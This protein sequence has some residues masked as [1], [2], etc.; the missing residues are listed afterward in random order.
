MW[1]EEPSEVPS[2]YPLKMARGCKGYQ[3]HAREE[4]QGTSG[5]TFLFAE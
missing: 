4:T 1:V 2:S 5:Y 3:M